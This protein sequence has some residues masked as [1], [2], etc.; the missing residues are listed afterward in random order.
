MRSGITFVVTA[1][2]RARLEALVSARGSPQKHVRRARIIL[3]TDDALG[4]ASIMAQ[5]GKSKTCVWR[6]QERYMVEGVDGLLRDKTRAPGIAP[7]ATRLDV[8]LENVSND[9]RDWLDEG[10]AF[11]HVWLNISSA[12]LRRNMP[13][14]EYLSAGFAKANVP[15]KHLIVE[16]TEGVYLDDRDDN[17]GAKIAQMRHHG[18]KVALDDFGTG[19]ASLTHLLTVPVDIIKI[20]RSFVAGLKNGSA[21]AAI[22]EGLSSIGQKLD[23]RL[24]AEG[25]ETESQARHLLALGCRIGQAFLYSPAVSRSEM[26][27]LLHLYAQWSGA[28]RTI[29][30]L[31]RRSPDEM[32]EGRAAGTE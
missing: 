32:S 15:L 29:G 5:T 4:T 25:I 9:V 12:D 3:L 13:V 16:V 11:Q 31:W 30:A 1:A 8:M 27:K 2:D 18:L 7:I 14:H 24:L 26:T 6:W 23:I 21:S 28:C 19:F 10:V 20:D 22:V 17:V